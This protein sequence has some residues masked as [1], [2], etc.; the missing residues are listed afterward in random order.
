MG[1]QRRGPLPLG[2]FGRGEDMSKLYATIN[3]HNDK[4]T[5]ANRRAFHAVTTSARS[6]S[7]SIVVTLSETGF[8]QVSIPNGS[9]S[10]HSGAYWCGTIAELR[11]KLGLCA[12]VAV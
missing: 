4:G 9:E 3:P 1:A 11:T 2:T 6:W 7:G 12:K 8:V 5:V 10:S